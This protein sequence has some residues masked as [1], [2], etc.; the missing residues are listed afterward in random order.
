MIMKLE[1]A[2]EWYETRIAQEDD[3]DVTAGIPAEEVDR[4]KTTD[5]AQPQEDALARLNVFGSLI[6]M[7]RRDHRLS[8]EELASKARVDAT[9]I[10]SIERDLTFV[11]KPRT[12]HQ[13]AAYFSLPDRAL[14][15]LSNVT[16]AHGSKLVEAAFRFAANS[17]SLMELSREEHVALAEFVKFLGSEGDD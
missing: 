17:E 2:K 15:K 13:L 6:H 4:V 16:T 11:P 1:L 12:V 7:L 9:E 8:V 14:L 3:L 10:V 5:L